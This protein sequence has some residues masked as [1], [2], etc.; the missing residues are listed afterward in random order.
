MNEM[1]APNDNKKTAVVDLFCG[2]G[3]LAYGLKS[4]GLNIAAGVDLDPR[5]K[6]PLE[7]NTG[8]TFSCKDI[9]DLTAEEISQWFGSADVKILAGCAPCQP[10]STYSQS[11]KSSDDRW[12]LLSEFQRLA[13]AL[14]PD[15]V[16]MENVVGLS[17]QPIWIK[18][19]EALEQDNYF[20]SWRKVDC[21]NFAIPQSRQRLV[22][23]ASKKGPIHF[24]DPEPVEVTTVRDSIADLP[25]IA[26][27]EGCEDDPM[28]VS[29]SL[30][31][32]N[33]K[34]IQASKAGGTWRDWPIGLRAKCHK[35]ASGKSYPSVY[36][37]MEWDKPAPTMTT[38]CYG[39][40]NGRFGHPDQDRAISLREAA[41]LQSFPEEY[42]FLDDN[43]PVTFSQLGTLIGN[44]VPP[45]L[46]EAIGKAII[47]HLDNAEAIGPR[48]EK[49]LPL[50]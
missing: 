2:A 4:A 28:H 1:I 50:I 20:V 35:K 26:A 3:G 42:K 9:S 10:F 49:L 15:I 27:G 8:A 33:L 45:K 24:P 34:R 19:V 44:A 11:R 16:T 6:V 40:G 46:G 36:G 13:I 43:D 48:D 30:T 47:S 14:K 22:L 32:I 12:K 25:P 17:S 38:Q 21:R 31:K 29:S 39:Y 7:A 37:R 5:C 18:F 41:I 23:L